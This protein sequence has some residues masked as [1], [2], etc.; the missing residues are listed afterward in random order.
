MNIV[1]NISG[2]F[3]IKII[4]VNKNEFRFIVFDL[5]NIWERNISLE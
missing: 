2:R 3:F 5:I 4:I 1:E